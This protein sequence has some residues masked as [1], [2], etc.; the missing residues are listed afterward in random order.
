MKYNIA[1]VWSSHVAT[2][3]T[4]SA[5]S[6]LRTPATHGHRGRR[7][8]AARPTDALAHFQALIFL[9]A[10]VALTSAAQN[11]TIDET[12]FYKSS[13]ICL[14]KT[15]LLPFCQFTKI[16]HCYFRLKDSAFDLFLATC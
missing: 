14:S 5:L 16:L 13:K 4:F 11:A 9:L 15:L 10:L 12:I 8:R 3:A 6:T 2:T 1:N 7:H